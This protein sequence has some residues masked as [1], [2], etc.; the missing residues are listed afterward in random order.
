MVGSL[1]KQGQPVALVKVDNLLYQVRPG[2]YLGR[3]T[4][5]SPRSERPT[6]CCAKSCRTPRASG[7]SAPRRSNCKRG[8]NEQTEHH[9]VATGG[10]LAWGGCSPRGGQHVGQAQSTVVE[11]VSSSL[12]GG[13]EVVRIDFSQPST[14][15]PAG[16]AIQSPARIALDI[17]GASNGLGRSSVELNQG[18]LRSLNVVTAGDRT[19]LVLNLKTA[20]GY[21]A[22]LQ[23]KSLLVS[24]DPVA[25][26]VAAGHDGN[27]AVRGEPQPRRPADQGP[28][29]PPR[30]DASGR[31][32][33]DLPNNQVGVDIRQQGQ[34]LVVEFLKSSLPEGLRRKLDVSD[35]GTPVQTVTTFQAGDRVRVVIEPKGQWEHSAYQ[36]D[37][38]F[39]VEVRQQKVDRPS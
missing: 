14:A 3:T 1:V 31:V 17:P 25:G 20:T 10:S 34:Q 29:L 2:N 37:N 15:V 32:M 8:R 27:G 12:Q 7:S 28:G 13:A 39:V 22:Q 35:F 33:V 4:E 5:R 16:F 26:A 24:L 38:Q 9:G 6:S 23:G 36:S 19:R 18:N 21:K 30:P 11:S